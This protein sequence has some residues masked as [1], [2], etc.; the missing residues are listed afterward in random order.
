MH[1]KGSLNSLVQKSGTAGCSVFTCGC[2]DQALHGRVCSAVAK[3]PFKT[4]AA[5]GGISNHFWSFTSCLK[6]GW[7]A[8]DSGFS[9]LMCS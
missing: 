1:T 7:F 6:L 8:F 3:P 4:W 2:V 5:T 9:R